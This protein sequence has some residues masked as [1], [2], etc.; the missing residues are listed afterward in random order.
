M[1]RRA[2]GRRAAKVLILRKADDISCVVDARASAV[3]IVG[4]RAEVGGLSA[5]PDDAMG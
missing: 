1:F 2:T 3:D 5:R 4:Q